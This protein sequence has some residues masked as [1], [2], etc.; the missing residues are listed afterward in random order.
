MEAK[1]ASE[2]APR[3]A[4]LL[5]DPKVEIESRMKLPEA[6]WVAL[7]QALSRAEWGRTVKEPQY[8]LTFFGTT[9]R[10]ETVGGASTWET[11]EPLLA[12][13]VREPGGASFRVAAKRETSVKERPRSLGRVTYVRV[14]NR[15]RFYSKEGRWVYDI[16][17]TGEGSSLEVA[18]KAK[19]T[20]EVELE[21]IGPRDATVEEVSRSLI[22]RTIDLVGRRDDSGRPVT[23]QWTTS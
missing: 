14:C 12:V 17:S 2:L 23:Y 9:R 1:L 3:L 18:E 5:A 6:Q 21:Y 19:R 22:S 16:T 4:P 10:R 20:F 11:T 13:D 7:Y 8:R 15:A